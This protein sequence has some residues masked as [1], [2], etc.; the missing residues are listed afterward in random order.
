MSQPTF[1]QTKNQKRQ[2]LNTLKLKMANSNTNPVARIKSKTVK[3]SGRQVSNQTHFDLDRQPTRVLI[4]KGARVTLNGYNP[5]PKNGLFHGSL[6]I[7]K[8]IV[9]ESDKSP[10]I[11]DFP[12]YVLVDFYQYC[13]KELISGMPTCIPIVPHEVRCN[14]N[15]C[16]RTYMPLALAYGK[17]AHTFQGQ[18]VG[19]V[20]P[21]RPVNAIQKIIVDPGKREFEGNNV[22]LFYQLYCHERQQLEMVPTTCPQRFILMETISRAHGYKT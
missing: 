20:P 19:P 21:G 13:G 7:V 9:Y 15:C 2:R 22:G 3:P 18:S 17:T 16:I 8:D 6:G 14:F 4:C 12:T 5:D 1:L 10:N 11:G